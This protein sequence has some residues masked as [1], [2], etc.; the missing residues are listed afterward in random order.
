MSQASRRHTRRQ[1]TVS[2]PAPAANDTDL[3]DS[4]SDF[5]DEVD[6]ILEENALEVTQHYRQR[7]GQ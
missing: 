5:L 1:S 6:A 2:T 3:V 4:M 7:G